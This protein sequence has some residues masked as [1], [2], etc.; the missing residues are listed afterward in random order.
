[1]SSVLSLVP[2]GIF[3]IIWVSSLKSSVT[4]CIS[5]DIPVVESI[6]FSFHYF[7]SPAQLRFHSL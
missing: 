7:C 3:W 5:P 1:M 2:A 4:A 6:F